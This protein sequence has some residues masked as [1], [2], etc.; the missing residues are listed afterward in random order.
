MD[1]QVVSSDAAEVGWSA[2]VLDYPTTP[3]GTEAVETLI[4]S[5]EEL[6]RRLPQVADS[7]MSRLRAQAANALAAAKAAVAGNRARAAEETDRAPRSPLDASVREWP[8][9]TLAVA[10]LLGLAV[11]VWTGWVSR[12]GR[13]IYSRRPA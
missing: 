7:E 13:G 6:L 2:R 3:R 5:I 9:A 4:C 1:A 10:A 11:G 8:R 12:S